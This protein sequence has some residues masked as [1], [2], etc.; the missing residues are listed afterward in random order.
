MGDQL[1]MFAPRAVVGL[2]V[3]APTTERQ[4]SLD[5]G[6][7]Y[8]IDDS[9]PCVKCGKPTTVRVGEDGER[10]ADPRGVCGMQARC[11]IEDSNEVACWDC[12]YERGEDGYNTVVAMALGKPTPAP[13]PRY[14]APKPVRSRRKIESAADGSTRLVLDEDVLRVLSASTIEG[15]AVRLPPATLDRDLYVRV[16]EALKAIGGKWKG[17]KARV[18][19]FE[20]D[21]AD[22]LD[23]VISTGRVVRAKDL[24]WYPTPDAL[25][26]ELVSRL[27][28]RPGML[29]LEPSAGEGAIARALRDA[30]AHVRCVEIDK[31]RCQALRGQGFGAMHADFMALEDA[32]HPVDRI[33]MNPPFGRRMDVLHVTRAHALLK[34]G[35]KLGAI[36]SAGV[37]FREDR[38][39]T[40]FRALVERC[41]GTIEE[42]PAGSF[43]ESGTSVGTV[44]VTM[45]AA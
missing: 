15:Q 6:G 12:L 10:G 43:V 28:V 27:D 16:D 41:G 37:R 17:G 42:L 44:I 3:A 23:A 9:L 4:W 7:R 11:V 24:G 2:P 22:A 18:H 20:D 26:R 19:V 35:G 14:M 32:F 25:A 8:R 36:M 34:P 40:E 29:A 39:A 13:S 31:G 33:A 45:E 30:G 38:I 1:D 21:P 5:F